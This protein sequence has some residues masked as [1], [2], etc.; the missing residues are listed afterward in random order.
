MITLKSGQGL[1]FPAQRES[2]RLGLGGKSTVVPHRPRK[3][4]GQT[5]LY[6]NIAILI[7]SAF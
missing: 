4:I 5:R 7:L 6:K 1:N 3:V 2:L